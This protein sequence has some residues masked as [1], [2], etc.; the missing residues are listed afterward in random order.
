MYLRSFIFLTLNSLGF[1]LAVFLKFFGPLLLNIGF[2][3]PVFAL[4]LPLFP[5]FIWLTATELQ[6]SVQVYLQE[7]FIYLFWVKLGATLLCSCS[8]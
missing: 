1:P 8:T 7:A 2:F 3:S 5:S 6:D 4:C